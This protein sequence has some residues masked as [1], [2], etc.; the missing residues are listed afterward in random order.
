MGNDLEPAQVAKGSQ[1]AV[2]QRILSILGIP[3][4]P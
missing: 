3:Q 4:Q 1:Q 2:L